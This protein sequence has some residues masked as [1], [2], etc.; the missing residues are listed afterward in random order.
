MCFGQTETKMSS[1]GSYARVFDETSETPGTDVRKDAET[2]YGKLTIST[3]RNG[4]LETAGDS[5]LDASDGKYVERRK[6]GVRKGNLV[7]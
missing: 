6:H 7:H 1:K 4:I 5:A 3:R 2:E